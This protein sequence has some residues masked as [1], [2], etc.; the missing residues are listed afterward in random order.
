MCPRPTQIGDPP[1]RIGPWMALAV[2]PGSATPRGRLA[3]GA[4]QPDERYQ[5]PGGRVTERAPVPLWEAAT[6]RPGAASG[7][8]SSF[9]GNCAT[10][11]Q[12]DVLA[13]RSLLLGPD[14]PEDLLDIVV[15]P[16]GV[17][18]AHSP[19]FIDDRIERWHSL[20]REKAS[21]VPLMR[22]LPV[23]SPVR[24]TDAGGLPRPVSGQ[25][26][27][28]R[29]RCGMSDSPGWSAFFAKSEVIDLAPGLV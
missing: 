7:L 12:A 4:Q 24:R 8:Q 6:G 14:V 11:R 15:E 17:L 18:V 23:H 25:Q 2:R 27:I 3:P 13:P 26:Y 19:E 16:G 21:V 28:V 9:H 20:T 22:P 5:G 10:R 29:A 1:T